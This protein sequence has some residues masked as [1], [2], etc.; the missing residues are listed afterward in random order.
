MLEG[1]WDFIR[2][3]SVELSIVALY[4]YL[5]VD[6]YLTNRYNDNIRKRAGKEISDAVD[7]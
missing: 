4:V 2:E 6:V 7:N 5:G 1:C 3:Y